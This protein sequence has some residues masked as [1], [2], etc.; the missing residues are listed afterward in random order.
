MLCAVVVLHS[1]DE[2]SKREVLGGTLPDN[3]I[4]FLNVHLTCLRSDGRGHDSRIQEAMK[5]V[6]VNL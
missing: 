1:R 5:Q 6:Q 2:T 3:D 4:G